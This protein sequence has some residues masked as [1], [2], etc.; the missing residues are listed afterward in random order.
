MTYPDAI[1]AV[2]IRGTI[3]GTGKGGFAGTLPWDD[4]EHAFSP[5]ELLQLK[6]KP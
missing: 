6:V 1:F 4:G 3:E 2:N 5:N